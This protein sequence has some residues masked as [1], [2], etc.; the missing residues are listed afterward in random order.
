MPSLLSSLG[1]LVM[2]FAHEG[3]GV[4]Q[5]ELLLS[6]VR[7][8]GVKVEAEGGPGAEASTGFGGDA[9]A[10]GAHDFTVDAGD[11]VGSGKGIAYR[12]LVE[13]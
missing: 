5:Q 1:F 9:G 13:S 10:P 12:G 2:L 8:T 7:V 6:G 3:I 4:S 11:V